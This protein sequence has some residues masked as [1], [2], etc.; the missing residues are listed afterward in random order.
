MNKNY[1]FLESFSMLL[2]RGYSLQES[3]DIC[4]RI[5][6]IEIIKDIK[7]RLLS[8]D[9]IENTLTKVRL[10][11][12]FIEYFQFFQMSGNLSEAIENSL[13]IC[14]TYD[15]YLTKIK[16]ECTYPLVL[17]IFILFF[18]LFV[19]VVLM[20]KVFDLFASFELTIHPMIRLIMYLFYFIPFVIF[21]VII[22]IFI[23]F[24][25]L[26]L[27]LK[28]K[29]IRI[30]DRYFSYPIFNFY[31][32]KYFSL[33]FVIFY[34]ELLKDGVDSNSIIIQLNQQLKYSD[35]KIVL[36]EIEKRMDKGILLE[37]IL[38]TLEY[39][40]ELLPIFFRMLFQYNNK[41]ALSDYISISFTKLERDLKKYMTYMTGGVYAFVACFVLMVYLTI[42]IP[43]MNVIS[44]I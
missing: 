1:L 35:I 36:Y 26:I 3:L 34:N 28:E 41:H 10:P 17:M 5:Y 39:F 15:S 13:R 19:V 11:L 22:M 31:L 40:D 37:D 42:I 7:N 20:P 2:K 16:K 43:M 14:K 30:V 27:S 4:Y 6:P 21:I 38:N 24:I 44:N 29:R 25:N 33:K 32:R 18:S 8:G 12:L 9:Y 23:L